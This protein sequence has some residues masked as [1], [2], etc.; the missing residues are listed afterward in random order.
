ML[1]T[2]IRTSHFADEKTEHGVVKTCA[3][4]TQLSKCIVTPEA[5]LDSTAQ[6]GSQATKEHLIYI[7]ACARQHWSTSSA[8]EGTK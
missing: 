4:S 1:R 8:E 2:Y 7:L 3:P 6:T 5:G